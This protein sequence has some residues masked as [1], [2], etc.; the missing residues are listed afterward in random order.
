VLALYLPHIKRVNPAFDESWII[1]RWLFHGPDAQPVFTVG[2]G[3]H[4][5]DHR[6]TVPG[7]YLANMSQIYPQ[8]RGQNHSI[9]LGEKVADLVALDL[10]RAKAPVSQV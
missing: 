4:I 5:P 1:D 10:A 3:S 9:L 2:A 6:T 7:L 8:D